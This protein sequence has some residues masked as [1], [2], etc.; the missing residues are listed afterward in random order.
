M[1][2]G[3]NNVMKWKDDDHLDGST[4]ATTE[5]EDLFE[6]EDNE[7]TEASAEN[8]EDDWDL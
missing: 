3:I 7:V 6:D 4:S 8:E 1:A 2:V 5:F